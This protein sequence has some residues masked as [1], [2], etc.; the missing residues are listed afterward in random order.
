M[1]KSEPADGMNAPELTLGAVGK[2]LTAEDASRKVQWSP[3]LAQTLK[4]RP[5]R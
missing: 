5:K 4:A 1:I 3:A 2:I